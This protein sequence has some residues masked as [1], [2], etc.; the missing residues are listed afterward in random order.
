M[1]KLY[2]EAIPICVDASSREGYRQSN[3]VNSSLD[4]RTTIDHI[5]LD[6][7]RC[8]SDEKYFL[9][10]APPSTLSNFIVQK[11]HPPER[12]PA[13]ENKKNANSER[14]RFQ[15]IAT[16]KFSSANIQNYVNYKTNKNGPLGI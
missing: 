5:A 12:M 1:H 15:S 6:E 4:M 16:N 3:P 11:R 2:S 10:S 14:A 7:D 13:R 9:P 8:S